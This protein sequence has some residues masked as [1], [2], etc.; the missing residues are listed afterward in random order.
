MMANHKSE[1]FLSVNPFDQVTKNLNELCRTCTTSPN[2][3]PCGRNTFII[4]RVNKKDGFGED[5]DIVHYGQDFRLRVEQI[6]GCMDDCLYLSSEHITPLS[7]SKFSRKQEVVCTP[8]PNG[9]TLFQFAWPDVKVSFKF[10]T[11]LLYH[12]VVVVVVGYYCFFVHQ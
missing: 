9:K 8:V 6:E 3:V 2:S 12:I 10:T 1:A 4:E 11:V 5:S 7:A